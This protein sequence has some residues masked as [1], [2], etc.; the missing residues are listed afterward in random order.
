MH[1]PLAQVVTGWF[2]YH[3]VPGNHA[4]LAAFRYYVMFQWRRTLRRR[5]QKDAL[6]WKE[7]ARLADCRNRAFS[8]HGLCTVLPSN[9][10][11]RSRMREFR[12]YL[13]GGAG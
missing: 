11:G 9:T 6:T 3:A 8:T 7:I 1:Q 2:A 5:S 10:Q 13:C 4:A 12:S